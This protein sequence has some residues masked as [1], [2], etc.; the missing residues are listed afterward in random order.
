MKY[1][2]DKDG[3]TVLATPSQGRQNFQEASSQCTSK[4]LVFPSLAPLIERARDCYT[5]DDYLQAEEILEAVFFVLEEENVSQMDG[6]R[7]LITQV[8]EEL[9]RY[10]LLRQK[11]GVV[12][13]GGDVVAFVNH[14]GVTL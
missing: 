6:G 4:N 3:W 12:K 8:E 1:I 9:D 7:K 5:K 14:K 10:R 2:T 13:V 11:Q